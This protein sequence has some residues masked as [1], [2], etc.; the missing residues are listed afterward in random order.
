MLI[1]KG[2]RGMKH[3]PGEFRSNRDTKDHECTRAR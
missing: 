3:Q 1:E 2:T